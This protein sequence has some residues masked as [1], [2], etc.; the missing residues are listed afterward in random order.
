MSISE[1]KALQLS[2][3]RKNLRCRLLAAKSCLKADYR[4]LFST[5]A[6]EYKKKRLV[7][8]CGKYILQ[9][10]LRVSPEHPISYENQQTSIGIVTLNAH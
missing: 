5:Y 1:K 2:E 8:G 3:N 4:T 6:F 9:W 7:S 10:K